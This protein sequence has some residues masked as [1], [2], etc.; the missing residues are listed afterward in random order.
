MY[1]LDRPVWASLKHAPRLAEGDELAKRYRPDINLFAS[2]RDDAPACLAALRDRVPAG[3]SIV[4]LQ[5]PPIRV[6]DGLLV[7][8][9]AAGVQMLATRP[10]ATQAGEHVVVELGD[11]DASDMVALAQLTQPGPFLSRTHVMGRFVGI[12]IDGRLAAMAGQRMRFPGY[13]EVSGVCTHPDFQGLGLASRLSSVIA[14][15][16]QRR[17][18][19]A[20]LHAWATNHAAIALYEKLGFQLRAAVNVVVL[21]RPP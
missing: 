11:D 17:G 6:P 19:Q 7:A 12:R 10:V 18:D 13:T 8:R 15:D 4:L 2:A 21:T 1:D 20:F 3:E 9:E 16:I 5:V 14:S